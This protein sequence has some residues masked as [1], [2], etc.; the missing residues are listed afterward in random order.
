MPAATCDVRHKTFFMTAKDLKSL[1]SGKSSALT[2]LVKRAAAMQSLHSCAT[3]HLPEPLRPHVVDV[4][5]NEQ[6]VLVILADNPTWAARMRFHSPDVL[7]AA[8]K[9]GV[10]A[11]QCQ[12][13]VRPARQT[14]AMDTTPVPPPP[15]Q[16][17]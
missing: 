11:T 3:D 10:P 14:Q 9:N 2:S 7:A 15:R 13:K 6:N 16:K 4:L 1:L 12:V 8:R 5:L 17:S